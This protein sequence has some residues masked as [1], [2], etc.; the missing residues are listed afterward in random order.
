LD[1]EA[2]ASAG[3]VSADLSRNETRSGWTLGTGVAV[4]LSRQWSAKME[5][6]YIDLGRRDGSW[7]FS[8][9]PAVN[10]SS[11]AYQNVVRGGLNYRF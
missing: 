2:T 11:R 10:D 1:S 6:L 3:A 8:G 5:Y 9:L 4:A 7:A